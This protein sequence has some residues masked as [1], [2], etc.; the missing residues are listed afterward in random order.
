MFLVFLF[1]FMTVLSLV[2]GVIFM[3]NN[4]II[5]KK[6]STKLM[7]FRV[8]FQALAIILALLIYYIK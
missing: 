7:S 2:V 6:Y 5:N 8:G 4:G 3:G 1:M